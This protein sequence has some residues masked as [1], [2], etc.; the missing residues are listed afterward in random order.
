MLDDY[1]EERA[2]IAHYMEREQNP[3]VRERFWNTGGNIDGYMQLTEII[4]EFYFTVGQ[5]YD[6]KAEDTWEK[7]IRD[8]NALIPE[9]RRYAMSDQQPGYLFKLKPKEELDALF[10]GDD[11]PR[12]GQLFVQDAPAA[13]MGAQPV[14]DESVRVEEHVAGGAAVQEVQLSAAPAEA[15]PEEVGEEK[16][17]A[18]TV[19]VPDLTH[20]D[21][22]IQGVPIADPQQ[23]QASQGF[24]NRLSGAV[25]NITGFGRSRTPT[26]GEREDDEKTPPAPIPQMG[27][28]QPARRRRRHR[29]PVRRRD[30]QRPAQPH[31]IQL[32]DQAFRLIGV[33]ENDA[34]ENWRGQPHA[35]AVQRIING[36]VGYERHFFRYE[37]HQQRIVPRFEH[38][39]IVMPVVQQRG[40][41]RDRRSVHEIAHLRGHP[42]HEILSAAHQAFVRN[43]EFA[44]INS[45]S[46]QA[47]IGEFCQVS[48]APKTL[49]I[50][51]HK[52]IQRTAL[53]ILC[54]RVHEHIQTGTT[55]ILLKRRPKKGTYKYSVWLTSTVLKAITEE[56]LCHRLLDATN[57]GTRPVTL[58]VKQNIVKGHIQELWKNKHTLL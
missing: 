44:R 49:Y 29:V 33:R 25:R 56:D 18:P 11:I 3:L 7:L 34:W 43:D 28:A 6:K 23:A 35:E 15:V 32:S 13:R 48:I 55:R 20:H 46:E 52:G 40:R 50:K 9:N 39:H 30:I 10:R 24:W 12:F 19:P 16:S 4:K 5:E 51:I 42:H 8:Y 47:R 53:Q 26:R 31:A 1:L 38:D 14:R 54:K 41:R 36:G 58:V 27:Q 37:D 57:N 2:K 22:Q 17:A 21:D 45:E